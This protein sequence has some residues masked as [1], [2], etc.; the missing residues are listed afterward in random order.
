MAVS[1]LVSGGCVVSGAMVRRSLLF[2]GVRVNS[3]ASM[4]EAVVLPYADVGRNA[5]LKKVVVDRGVVIPDGLVVGEDPEWDAKRFRRSENGVCLITQEM[6]NTM[7]DEP[8]KHPV[9]LMPDPTSPPP[10]LPA[11]NRVMPEGGPSARLLDTEEHDW[12]L[13]PI[14]AC[15]D[16][17]SV[18][19]PFTAPPPA[20]APAPA[21]KS[22]NDDVN[23]TA[24]F[25][26]SLAAFLAAVRA[27]K[28][29]DK[30]PS[31]SSSS[32]AA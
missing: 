20:P 7:P 15:A 11:K 8:T 19:V 25:A 14:A 31:S 18:I 10:T 28:G 2:T 1:S 3:F 12:N 24:D 6:I 17:P 26:K 22:A 21:A 27:A 4:E 13:P 16:D 29:L 30:P 5:R 23:M 32:E 9:P